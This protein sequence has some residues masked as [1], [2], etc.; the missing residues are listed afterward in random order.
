MAALRTA[1]CFLGAK[2]V[3][4]F[5]KLQLVQPKPYFVRK[6]LKTL[7]KQFYWKK[8]RFQLRGPICARFLSTH[9]IKNN[10]EL[11]SKDEQLK[12]DEKDKK[13]PLL[14]LMAWL[15][16]NRR[17]YMKLVNFYMEQNFDVVVVT[18]Y[19]KQLLWPVSGTQVYK[20]LLYS[21]LTKKLQIWGSMKIVA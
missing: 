10:L 11:I 13:R 18:V 12:S 9:R 4:H 16:A 17:H 5:A 20:N 1:L 3:G 14:V 7:F 2:S 21:Y 8:F 6:N 15:A 19:P